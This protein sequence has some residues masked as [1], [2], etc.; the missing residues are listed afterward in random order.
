[1]PLVGTGETPSEQPADAVQPLAP[2]QG[3][4]LTTASNDWFA[5]A[6]TCVVCHQNNVDEAGNDVSNGEYWR[7]TM[8]AN[9]ALDPY[10][11]AS[12][13]IE[14]AENPELGPAIEAKCSTCHMPM[15]H[16]SDAAQGQQ[17]SSLPMAISTPRT[18]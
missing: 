16:L 5:T 1:M 9:S 6:G 10:Y 15:A 7:S 4:V 11:L 12:V 2:A 18:R 17:A 13:S 8:M 3:G 14:V